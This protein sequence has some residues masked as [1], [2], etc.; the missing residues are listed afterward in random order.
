M[1]EHKTP[2]TTSQEVVVPETT[3]Q[4]EVPK[5]LVPTKP[6]GL[7]E[8]DLAEIESTVDTHFA[9][10]ERQPGSVALV[11]TVGRLGGDAQLE[12]SNQFS[13]LQTRVGS[14]LKDSEGEGAGIPSEL[15]KC[16]TAMDSLNPNAL[17]QPRGWLRKIPKIGPILLEIAQRY[18]TVQSQIDGIV[19]TLKANDDLLLEDNIQLEQLY[20]NVQKAQLQIQK[21]AFV[22][23][24]LWQKIEEKLRAGDLPERRNLQRVL[25]RVVVR[26]QDLRTM[27]QANAQSFA[28]IAM[29]IDTN[30]S[31]S[32]SINRMVIVVRS[33]LTVALTI[34]VAVAHQ[35]KAIKSIR[36]T[37]EFAEE[38]IK[39]NARQIREGSVDAARL[40]NEPVLALEAMKVGF[41]ELMT[42]YDEV[43]EIRT[44][45][46]EAA[47]RGVTELS[48]MTRKLQPRTEALRASTEEQGAQLESGDEERLEE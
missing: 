44:Q 47:R 28:G 27:E 43:E 35:R 24:L 15:V 34:S 38:L 29:I 6:A 5:E 30:V 39:S 36:V 18:E 26:V 45:G 23:E 17:M 11:R 12:A 37:K 32:D 41:D 4:E 10:V 20:E 19:G 42:A 33:L 31:V 25:N 46:I 48:E 1:N 8:A 16:R 22:G 14:L 21:S 2:K 13:L 40:E 7:T 3:G 9:E